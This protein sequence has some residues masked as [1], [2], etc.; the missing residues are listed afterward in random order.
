M[1]EPRRRR[2]PEEADDA[3]ADAG[4]TTRGALRHGLPQYQAFGKGSHTLAS[5]KS[6][7]FVRSAEDNE[8]WGCV[9]ARSARQ[10]SLPERGQTVVLKER[11][12]GALSEYYVVDASY[13]SDNYRMLFMT[14]EDHLSR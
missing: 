6:V 2:T 14:Q 13:N 11:E 8:L 12:T 1:K 4:K 10:A 3:R 9:V 5:D 7:R